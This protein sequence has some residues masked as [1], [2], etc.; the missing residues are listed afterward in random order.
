[1]NI[2]HPFLEGNGRA[3]RMW[4]DCILKKEI[5][6]IIDWDKIGETPL[7]KARSFLTKAPY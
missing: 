4:L 6:R 3:M 2:A 1:M 5:K 7:A